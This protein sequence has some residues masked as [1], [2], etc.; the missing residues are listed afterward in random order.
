MSSPTR[1]LPV[2]L[3]D[4]ATRAAAG[5][6]VVLVAQL[7]LVLDATVVN[8]ALPH[9]GTDLGF[10]AASL[11]W[12][13]NAYTLA[14]GGLL[15][16]GGRLGDVLGRRRLFRVGLSVFTLASLLGGLAQSPD[17]LVLAR[18]LQGVGAALA[19]PSVLALLTTSA[20]DQAARTRAFALFAAVSSGGASLG[21][22]LGGIVT[23]LGSWRWTLFINVPIGLVV[24][25][26]VGRVVAETP[27]RPGRFDVV[28]AA[29]ATLGAVLL[30]Q[31]LIGTPQH[32]WTS[33]R[34][35]GGVA[36][37]LVMLAVLARTETRI[38]HPII[39]PHLLRDPRRVAALAMMGLLMAG[40]LAVFFLV[41]QY[42][43]GVL[44]LGPVETGLA[45]LP[46]SLSIFTVS[47]IT[48]RLVARF[49]TAPLMLAG[50][51]SLTAS[52]VLMSRLEADSTF[53][54]ALLLPMV[55]NGVGAGLNFMPLT[56]TVLTGVEDEHAGAA[57][58]LL[59][60]M[61]QLGGAVGVAVIVSVYASRAVPGQVL[62]GLEQAFWTAAAFGAACL[63]TSIALLWHQRSA[64][65]RTLP[66][67][68]A[69][70]LAPVAAATEAA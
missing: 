42:D 53:L 49:G 4:G 22:L 48:P 10:G 34:T 7:M 2:D 66:A 57:S 37:G 29:T 35:L 52:Y 9:I 45:F 30:V 38:A 14:F 15:L 69:A 65:V 31:A 21:L 50:S 28:G 39:Q 40:Q 54:G 70:E 13:L 51:I 11:S 23:D 8:V 36:L 64:R 33:A 67:A 24:V 59:Q 20:P 60:T 55:L 46:L 12:V 41:V 1:D 5:I 25:A 47:R 61:Q 56:T 6:A 3:P 43:E 44:G 32:G 18:A 27:R 26:I 68:E 62:P 58:G 17:Q 16:L 63:A 19:A